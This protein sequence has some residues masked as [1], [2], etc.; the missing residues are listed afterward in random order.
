MTQQIPSHGKH[1][2][3]DLSYELVEIHKKMLAAE[4][5]HK[6]K[7]LR[8][9]L[10]H[11]SEGLVI[12]GIQPFR[13]RAKRLCFEYR[14]LVQEGQ[15]A[16]MEAID[17]WDPEKGTLATYA[18]NLIKCRM[19]DILHV[20]N[21]PTSRTRDISNRIFQA[22][23]AQKHAEQKAGRTPTTTEI[24]ASVHEIAKARK[25]KPLTE[26]ELRQGL[27]YGARRGVPLDAPLGRDGPTLGSILPSEQF[28]PQDQSTIWDELYAL[29]E[30]VV[31]IAACLSKKS[32]RDLFIFLC[33][34]GLYPGEVPTKT[35]IAR[36]LE[37]SYQR[38]SQIIDKCQKIL[39]EEMRVDKKEIE[40]MRERR[41]YLNEV[42]EEILP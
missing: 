37:L 14:E 10:I 12:R 4:T 35:D 6:R 22:E 39:L 24:M 25:I 18:S 2:R 9:R 8:E 28:N 41:K 42:L 20:G 13:G 26:K 5:S 30:E 7:E 23:R 36:I 29:N 40:R 38:V 27:E 32:Q 1:I 3:G 34:T 11:E 17:K 33:C 21:S 31:E 16:L 19:L 15:C